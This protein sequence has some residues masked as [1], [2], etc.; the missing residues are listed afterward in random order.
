MPAL[1]LADEGIPMVEFPQSNERM[2][3]AFAGLYEAV[4][5]KRLS[6]NGDQAYTTQVLN[7]VQRFNERGWTL[8]KAKSRGKIDA[9]Y[10]LA[11]CHARAVQP[12]KERAPLFV[13]WA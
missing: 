9:A 1:F 8:A 13:G 12:V 5:N 6:H 2:S 4:M 11:L 10:A 3:P 7:G